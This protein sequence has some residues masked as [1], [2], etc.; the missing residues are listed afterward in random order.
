MKIRIEILRFYRGMSYL[1][2][3]LIFELPRGLN[4]SPRSKSRGIT[5]QGNQGYALTSRAALKN[6]LSGINLEDQSFLDI[7]SGK[8]G[9]IIYSH[10]LGCAVSAGI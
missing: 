6:M 5:L 1:L 2:N 9:A 8:G 7:G 4:I 3:Y 10:Q